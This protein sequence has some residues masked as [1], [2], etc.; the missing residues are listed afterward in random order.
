[1]GSQ[2]EAMNTTRYYYSNAEQQPVGPLGR[3]ELDAL[4]QTGVVLPQSP[5][6]VEG[7]TEWSTV[8]KLSAATAPVADC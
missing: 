3:R 5:I 6:L 2:K 8:R 7:E 4:I 1:M